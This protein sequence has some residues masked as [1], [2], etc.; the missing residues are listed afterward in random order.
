MEVAG[1]GAAVADEVDRQAVTARL[2]ERE[3]GARRHRDH[4]AQ[5]ADHA[6]VTDTGLGRQVAIVERALDTVRE[7]FGAAQELA[8]QP[9]QQ[10]AGF[11]PVRIGLA[12]TEA[13][14]GTCRVQ[15]DRQ[16]RPQVAVQRAQHVARLHP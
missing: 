9:V 12:E 6:D 5:V 16:D 2:L 10:L 7:A 14:K 8:A 3:G 15:V 13:G 1:G 4:G 11:R